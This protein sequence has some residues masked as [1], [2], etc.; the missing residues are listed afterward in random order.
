METSHL[1]I[2]TVS[3]SWHFVS[4]PAAISPIQASSIHFM[5]IFEHLTIYC[6]SWNLCRDSAT[7]SKPGPQCQFLFREPWEL[8]SKNPASYRLSH[9][10]YCLSVHL[11]IGSD[12][13]PNFIN[14]KALQNVA[15][16]H[17]SKRIPMFSPHQSSWN[18]LSL[19]QTCHLES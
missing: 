4:I 12:L 8:S 1:C 15:V 9:G 14:L 7:V 19:S 3:P 11:N 17:P 18:Y 6:R 13:S 10:P 16:P 5:A 2:W